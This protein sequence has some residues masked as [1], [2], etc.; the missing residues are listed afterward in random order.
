MTDLDSFW[1]ETLGCREKDLDFNE[2]KIVVKQEETDYNKD[3]SIKQIDIFELKANRIVSCSNELEE[4]LREHK[5]TLFNEEITQSNLENT[6][7]EIEEFLGPA[8][9]SYTTEDLFKGAEASNCRQ[10]TQKDQEKLDKLKQES[11]EEE[12]ENSIGDAEIQSR[13]VFGKFIRKELVAV[14]SYVVW[15]QTIGFPDV[16]VKE[17]FRGNGYGKQVVSKSTE[18][19]LENNLIP[20]YRTIENWDYSVKLAK[21]LGYK[22]Y[23][24]TYLLKLKKL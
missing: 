18:H 11:D 17:K 1:A 14:S 6:G 8:F 3:R 7:L 12:I 13:P 15:D 2:S 21:S 4:K 20:V 9:L 19:I 10:L 24:T 22:K 23:A 16:F 5:D